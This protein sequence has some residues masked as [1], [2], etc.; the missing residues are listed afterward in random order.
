M[1]KEILTFLFKTQGVQV[2]DLRGL[3]YVKQKML[4]PVEE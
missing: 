3:D 1:Q 4:T 2:L